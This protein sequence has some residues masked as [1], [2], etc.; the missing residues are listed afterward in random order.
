M[1]KLFFVLVGFL[2]IACQK[3]ET[4]VI[5]VGAVVP[6]ASVYYPEEAFPGLEKEIITLPSGITV[7]KL[8]TLYIIGG[9][10]LL[11]EEQ[12]NILS[13]PS[14]RSAAV[15]DYV[16][17]WPN[18]TVYYE[19]EAGFANIPNVLSA[20]SEWETKT[21]IRFMPK[22]A[23]TR[24]YVVF[25]N[26]VD[27]N[28]SSIGRVSGAQT[29]YLSVAGS[30]RGTAIHEIGHA[31]GLFHEQSRADRDQYVNILWNNIESGKEHN[32]KLYTQNGYNGYDIGDFDFNSVMMYHPKEFSKNDNPTI[33][34]KDGTTH[35]YQRSYLSAGD[36]AG[37]KF[38]YGPPF[39]KNSAET[40]YYNVMDDNW[41]A[42]YRIEAEW[43][44]TLYFYSDPE[45]T[46]LLA[47]TPSPRLI[48][49][50]VQY[51]WGG[52]GMNGSG[53][54][55]KAVIPVGTASYWLG[56]DY[57]LEMSDYGN[58]VMYQSRTNSVLSPKR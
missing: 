21:C 10:V 33:T 32:F 50:H 15:D 27:D 11:T 26:S 16:R 22:T 56:N 40:V 36:I 42:W 5:P 28:S 12:V 7:A 25:R 38:L 8:D 4:D 3:V 39:Y 49:A 34:K 43:K 2:T 54:S 30:S 9:D 19:F 45:C 44:N 48:N 24:D 23:S 47:V 37:I 13:Q 6:D 53:S 58:L 35:V 31:V 14:T 57:L 51:H 29:L 46:N 1:K 17:Y 41:G 20:M 18:G 52:P 55:Y